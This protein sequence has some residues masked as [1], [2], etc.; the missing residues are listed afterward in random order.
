M[1]RA[2]VLD[3]PG[4]APGGVHDLDRGCSRGSLHRPDVCH[5]SRLRALSAQIRRPPPANLQVVAV[6]PSESGLVIKVRA[7][8]AGKEQRSGA[9]TGYSP[10]TWPRLAPWPADPPR[11]S[12]CPAPRSDPELLPRLTKKIHASR[13]AAADLGHALACDYARGGGAGLAAAGLGSLP[14]PQRGSGTGRFGRDVTSGV[15]AC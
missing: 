6:R 10:T 3:A 1:R 2:E 14:G 15:R 5:Q 8:T 7:W 12:G 4:A 9:G 13:S 11:P